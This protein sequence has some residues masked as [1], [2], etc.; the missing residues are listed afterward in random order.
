MDDTYPAESSHAGSMDRGTLR[1][2]TAPQP[3]PVCVCGF[4][5][6]L[7]CVSVCVCVLALVYP[8]TVKLAQLTAAPMTWISQYEEALYVHMCVR[9]SGGRE[10]GHQKVCYCRT[11]DHLLDPRSVRGLSGNSAVAL[12]VSFAVSLCI[13]KAKRVQSHS[14]ALMVHELQKTAREK[15][16][17]KYVTAAQ[18]LFPHNT[19]TSVCEFVKCMCVDMVSRTF[20]SL[21]GAM[22]CGH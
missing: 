4:C 6:Q 8:S 5:F 7:V 19:I 17:S 21:T 22:G 9:T 11:T 12:C 18:L 20:D 13:L 16:L 15:S 1:G 14:S 3:I 10:E 2:E